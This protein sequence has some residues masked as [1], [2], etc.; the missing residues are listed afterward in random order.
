MTVVAGSAALGVCR[1]AQDKESGGSAGRDADEETGDKTETF[2]GVGGHHG[3][4]TRSGRLLCPS[5]SYLI[6]FRSH[7]SVSLTTTSHCIMPS[8]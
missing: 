2:R 7:K 6:P 3:Q 4:G 8:T 5:H 1:G